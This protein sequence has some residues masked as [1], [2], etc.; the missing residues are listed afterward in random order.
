MQ[1]F[2]ETYYPLYNHGWSPL[3]GLRT[4]E[5]MYIRA[6]RPELYNMLEDRQQINNLYSS[7]PEIVQDLEKRMSDVKSNLVSKNQ[8][9][10]KKMSMDRDT[11]QRL[12]SLGY[13]ATVST[14][15]GT[16]TSLDL[17]PDPKD[18]ISTLDFLNMATYYYSQG[19]IEQA[20][21]QFK[22]VIAINPNDVF[23]HF[24]LGYIYDQQG[25]T[26]LA[27]QEFNETLRLDPRYVSA[28]NDLGTVYNRLGQYEKALEQFQ[29]ALDLNP[30]D[31]ELFLSLILLLL[32]L[33]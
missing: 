13:V 27:I 29:K 9:Q 31:V 18:M 22:T 2:C 19:N 8:T 23:A 17:Y 16:D 33:I 32:F 7:H 21:E 5:W 4:A 28:Y 20:I 6:P 10:S 30:E 24:V 15:P 3:E 26:D 25:K 11:A 1:L 14:E 12:R